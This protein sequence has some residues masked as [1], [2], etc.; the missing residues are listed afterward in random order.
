RALGRQPSPQRGTWCLPEV[1][2]LCA[3]PR[4]VRRFVEENQIKREVVELVAS[5]IQV[6]RSALDR[7]VRDRRLTSGGDEGTDRAFQEVLIDAAVLVQESQRGL[8]P[9]CKRLALGMG[10]ALVV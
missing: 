7:L 5:A 3:A 8:E 9:V 6:G 4:D 2:Q 10:Q 1:P